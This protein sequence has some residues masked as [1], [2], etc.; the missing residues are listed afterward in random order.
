MA[1]RSETSLVNPKIFETFGGEL[2]I[3]DDDP[4]A[5]TVQPGARI[6]PGLNSGRPADNGLDMISTQND[7]NRPVSRTT[8]A[9]PMCVTWGLSRFLL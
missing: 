8:R 2:R 7:L 1:D 5:R 6:K 3:P 4:S 9:I